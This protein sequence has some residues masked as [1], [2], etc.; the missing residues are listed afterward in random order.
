MEIQITE[1]HR[2]VSLIQKVNCSTFALISETASELGIKKT[3]LMQYIED[4]PKN[5]SIQE[6]TSRST[7]P[8]SSKFKDLSRDDITL[9][10]LLSAIFFRYIVCRQNERPRRDLNPQPSDP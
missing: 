8:Q 1:I 6:I 3:A 5:F 4:H 2:I 7:N 9:L 10:L